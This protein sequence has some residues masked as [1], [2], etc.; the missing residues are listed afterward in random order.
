ML[1]Q[2]P[3][4]LTCFL[5]P[6]FRP[7]GSVNGLRFQRLKDKLGNRSNASSKVEFHAAYAERVGA[8]GEG[9]RTIIRM[10]Q[11]TRLDC[12]AAAAGQMRMGLAQAAHHA[13]HRSVFQRRLIDQPAMRAVLA[14]LALES[15][16]NAAL[17]FRLTRAYDS[18][19]NNEA[20]AEAEAAYARLMTPAVKYLVAKSAPSF[21]YET[22]E[23]LGGNG[24]VEDLPMARLYR[25]A[26]LNAIWEGSGTVMALDILRA[27][28][29]SREAAE[30]VIDKLAGA[31][32]APGL[33][34]AKAIKQG[35]G[36][37]DAESHAR[38]VAEKLARL[39]ALAALHEAD[40]NLA[41]AYAATRLEGAPQAT[42]GACDL[43]SVQSLALSRA[44]P[45]LFG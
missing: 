8:E 41:E 44:L 23:C 4:G 22:L 20:E 1:A 27:I 35:L 6:R 29:Q 21:I 18:A 11:L 43:A 15:E 42:W 14:D 3:A 25:G 36:A 30:N 7:D 12:T 33:A 5:L 16:A 37:K 19:R 31:A 28:R 40:G 38:F 2:A 10:V 24:Y 9:V 34:A 39:G 13:S 26:P 32:S 17:V 45:Q